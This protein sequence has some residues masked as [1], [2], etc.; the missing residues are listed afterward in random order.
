[1]YLHP[2][3]NNKTTTTTKQPPNQTKTRRKNLL[4]KESE[5]VVVVTYS[6]KSIVSLPSKSKTLKMKPYNSWGERAQKLA[7]Q[8]TYSEK[9]TEQLKSS[10]TNLN[11]ASVKMF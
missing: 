6:C 11:R 4:S 2:Y 1:L 5:D 10:S 3:S 8:E 9:S 7:Q